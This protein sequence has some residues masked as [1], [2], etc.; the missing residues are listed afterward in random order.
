MT[1]PLAQDSILGF[2]MAE[3]FQWIKLFLDKWTVIVPVI[4]FLASSAG[5]TFSAMD[6]SDKDI[7]I[8]D[9]KEQIKNIANYYAEPKKVKSDC[10]SCAVFIENHKRK[11][12]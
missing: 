2:S 10:G 1:Q 12:H 9:G 11:E 3:A 4:L 8:Q 7:E 6:N 5:L